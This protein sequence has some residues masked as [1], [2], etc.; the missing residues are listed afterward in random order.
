MSTSSI[1]AVTL[2]VPYLILGPIANSRVTALKRQPPWAIYVYCITAPA[3]VVWLFALMVVITPYFWLYPERHAHV[4]DF[5]GNEEQKKALSDFRAAMRTKP[6]LR[7]LFERLHLVR[8]TD[9]PWPKIL[10]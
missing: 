2:A 1:I 6:F 3:C 8:R 10:E 7:R 9:P 5:E 4:I